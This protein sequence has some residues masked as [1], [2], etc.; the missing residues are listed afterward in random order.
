LT[1]ERNA[2]GNSGLAKGGLTCFLETFVVIQTFVLRMNNSAKNPALRQVENRL[3]QP[4][5]TAYN[6]ETI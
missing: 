6:L 3:L 1:T 4:L 5:A 2:A